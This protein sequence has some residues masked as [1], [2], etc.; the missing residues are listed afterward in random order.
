MGKALVMTLTAVLK[1]SS[2]PGYL[3][4]IPFN[5]LVLDLECL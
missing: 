2:P 3:E 1:H 4:A 5:L